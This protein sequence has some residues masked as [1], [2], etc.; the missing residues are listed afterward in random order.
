M[1]IAF[2]SPSFTT[3]IA[4][5]L[6]LLNF[7][8]LE[9][10]D[11]PLAPHG[12]VG[13]M[14][15]IE[16]KELEGPNQDPFHASATSWTATTWSRCGGHGEDRGPGLPPRHVEDVVMMREQDDLR[17]TAQPTQQGQGRVGATIV[18]MHQ[19][20]VGDELQR[21]GLRGMRLKAATRSAR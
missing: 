3:P 11:R 4:G 8:A 14:R 17:G 5:W 10:F 2:T 9:S 1:I 12:H 15:S 16:R 21:L 7:A 13:R 18:E 19:A 20:V 6:L